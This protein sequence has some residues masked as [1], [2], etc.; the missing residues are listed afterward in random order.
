MDS[1][2]KKNRE[3]TNLEMEAM[4]LVNEDIYEP[5]VTDE[6]K[7]EQLLA[8]RKERKAVSK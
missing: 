2:Y 6:Q 5:A 8:G 7:Y 1:P 4:N 3:L